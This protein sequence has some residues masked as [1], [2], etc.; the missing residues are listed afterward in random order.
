[1]PDD[2]EVDAYRAALASRK[3]KVR[4]CEKAAMI[5]HTFHAALG[6]PLLYFSAAW[7]NC[8]DTLRRSELSEC[9]IPPPP[10]PPSAG[11]EM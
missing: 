1:M 11:E 2:V 9:V 10:P 4:V 3:D 6:A 7:I 8:T 5:S